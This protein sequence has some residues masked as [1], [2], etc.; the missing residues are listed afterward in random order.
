MTHE[1]ATSPASTHAL[2]RAEAA[3][4]KLKFGANSQFFEELRGR[5]EEYFRRTGKRQRDCW[6]MYLKTAILLMF[7]A[8]SYLLLVFVAQTW[9][10]AI[11]LTIFLGLVA[12]GIGFNIQHDGG[13][14]AYSNRPWV[15][16]LMS[17]SLDL[18]GGSSY[19]WARKHNSIH[20]S[21]ANI[22]GHDDDINIGLLGR[23]SPH[24]KR[25]RF[26][27]LQQFYLWALYGF[28]PIKW[29]VYDDFRDLLT[30]RI[31][32]HK[33]E[34][35][36]GWDLVTFITGKVVFFSLALVIPLLLHPVWVVLL[37]YAAASFV[38][39][40]VLSVVF[41][42]AHCVEQAAFPMPRQDTGRMEAAWAVHQL[43]TTVNFARRSRLL[44]WLVGGLNFQIEHHLF[45]RICHINYP[46]LSKV[47]E[48]TCREFTVNYRSHPSLLAGLVSH[49][50]WLRRMGSVTG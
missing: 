21:Y 43:E 1:Q 17:M 4:G 28:L 26:H 23:L 45:P 44:S 37:F 25:L 50:R 39:G 19:V 20:H 40:V 29:Q 7:F 18:L 15:N 36:R 13:H 41:Q 46:A 35:P 32:E 33:F 2:L 3:P 9:W 11:P 30:G 31:G 14:Q 49:F 6:Q 22:T 47:V 42:L 5:V 38:Q 10:Q 48:E 24:Q 34:R 8:A 12:A 27:R 16:K